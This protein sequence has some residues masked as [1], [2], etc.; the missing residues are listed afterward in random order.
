MDKQLESESCREPDLEQIPMADEEGEE[1]TEEEE[2]GQVAAGAMGGGGGLQDHQDH[3]SLSPA[4]SG[5]DAIV[6]EA[7]LSYL[8]GYLG[9]ILAW[10]SLS[11]DSAFMCIH[12]EMAQGS[13]LDFSHFGSGVP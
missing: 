1:D 4:R 9:S 11:L 8:I 3:R 13:S 2:A 5:G 12:V 10:L 7:D 6:G